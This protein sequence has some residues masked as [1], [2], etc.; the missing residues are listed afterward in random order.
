[1]ASIKGSETEKLVLTAFAGESQARNRYT[2][3]AGA[4][5]KEGYVQIADIF[6]ET[7]DHEKE[8]A[9]RM[10]K[11]LEGGEVNIT[12]SFPAGIIA[13]TLVNLREAAAGERHEHAELYPMIAQT[14]SEEGFDAVA[15][16]FNNIAK[17][18][19][20][21]E[22]R[23]L[24]FV[25]ILEKNRAFKREEPVFWRCRNCGMVH[26]GGEA[27]Q[28]CP[29]CLHPQAHFEILCKPW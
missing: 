10:F 5:R 11:F 6:L 25:D 19:K 28:V 8:H 18:E 29:A 21:H 27:P 2:Y 20:H 22:E 15:V 9:K 16:A 24:A 13:P 23:Y 4:A 14:A 26:H 1:M 3:Y 17:A 7:A 12:A